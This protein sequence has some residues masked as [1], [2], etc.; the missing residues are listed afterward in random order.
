[1]GCCS[2][3]EPPVPQPGYH[4]HGNNIWAL[5]ITIKRDQNHQH[6]QLCLDYSHP[7][8]QD[9]KDHMPFV[10]HHY[11]SDL[12]PSLRV[13]VLSTEEGEKPFSA[14]TDSSLESCVASCVFQNL[15]GTSSADVL[16]SQSYVSR[17]HQADRWVMQ[18]LTNQKTLILLTCLQSCGRW[19]C[20]RVPTHCQAGS[21]L[22][23]DRG[24]DM[25]GWICS[26]K[27]ADR[28]GLCGR[29]L[30]LSELE[31]A[32]SAW[33]PPAVYMQGMWPPGPPSLTQLS[34]VSLHT[35]AASFPRLLRP[36][37]PLILL[38]GTVLLHATLVLKWTIRHSI[39]GFYC[40]LELCINQLFS[41]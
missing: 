11:C 35:L 18:L 14:C 2:G 10:I 40:F 8:H 3:M 32:S 20:V 7:C 21:V 37:R 17:Q 13:S 33:P 24:W 34:G 1:M 22:H 29:V 28:P 36:Y 27:Y 41:V 4:H 5:G 19:A 38:L 25:E 9:K 16:R 23:P 31:S 6:I 39:Q 26:Q 12:G 15:V 30:S